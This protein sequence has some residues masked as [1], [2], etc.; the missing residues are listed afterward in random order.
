MSFMVT[1]SDAHFLARYG[2]K[3]VSPVQCLKCY[4]KAGPVPKRRGQVKWFNA[5]K[6]YGFLVGEDE[7]EVFFHQNQLVGENGVEP[8]EGQGARFHV[9]YAAKGPQALNVELVGV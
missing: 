4:W 2:V 9:R 1:R 7:Q 8:Q 5:R 3:V 6:G